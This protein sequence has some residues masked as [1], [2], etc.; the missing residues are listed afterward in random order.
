MIKLSA[1][2]A[3]AFALAPAAAL[4][5]PYANVEVNAGFLGSDYQAATTDLHLGY[6]GTSGDFSWY[7]QGG[8]SVV[9]TDGGDFTEGTSE[10]ELSGKVGASI[11]ATEKLSFYGEL[12]G[13]TGEYENAY[14]VKAG[15]K[16][17][18]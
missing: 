8:P 6:E 16:Y 4:A 3:T 12:S 18:F 10:M 13:I 14:G 5:G 7:L 17:S 1:A 9:S 15:A 2:L 11:A